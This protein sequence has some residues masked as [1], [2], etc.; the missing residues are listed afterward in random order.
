MVIIHLNFCS[1]ITPVQ[2]VQVMQAVWEKASTEDGFG[3]T[4]LSH[5]GDKIWL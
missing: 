2:T 5:N 4:F 1:P 3:G